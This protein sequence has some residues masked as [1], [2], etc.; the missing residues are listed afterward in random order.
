MEMRSVRLPRSWHLA[1]TT[2]SV[3][4][5]LVPLSFGLS[6]AGAKAPAVPWAW[7]GGEEGIFPELQVG[8]ERMA[9]AH[10]SLAPA[11]QPRYGPFDV[12]S[13]KGTRDLTSRMR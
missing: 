3:F 12:P 4:G 1:C 8:L 2:L 5:I 10:S 11:F 9:W 7:T 6:Y 13:G